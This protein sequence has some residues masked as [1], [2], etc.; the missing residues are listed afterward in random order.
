M[1][2]GVSYVRSKRPIYANIHNGTNKYVKVTDSAPI[3][4]V[5]LFST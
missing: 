5:A 3:T 1:Y 4:M 2:T